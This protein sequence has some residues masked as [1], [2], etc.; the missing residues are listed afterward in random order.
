V[1][2]DALRGLAA[3]WVLLF[4]MRAGGHLPHLA[5]RWP[6]ALDTVIAHGDWGVVIFFALSGFVISHATGTSPL[7]S[8]RAWLL[9]GRR[10]LRLLPPY[11]VSLFVTVTL[12]VVS[13]HFVAGKSYPLPSLGRVAVHLALL[14]DLL[15]VPPLASVYWSLAVELQL[16]IAFYVSMLIVARLQ[17]WWSANAAYALVFGAALLGE[18]TLTRGLAQVPALVQRSFLPHWHW[19]ALGAVVWRWRIA[20][21]PEPATL[22]LPGWLSAVAGA[23]PLA[24]LGAV[25]YSLYLLHNPL[26]G[27]VFRVGRRLGLDTSELG[28][29]VS[30]ALATGVSLLAA[31]A[32]YWAVERPSMAWSRRLGASAKRATVA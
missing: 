12:G 1:E 10:C 6:S 19:F 21:K 23:A 18:W 8:S 32:M 26:T 27:A 7:S 13:T 17:R 11:W 22:G 31:A 4:H 2:L 24:W 29:C 5:Q 20:G 3:F 28:E 30:L 14:Q 9:F 15:N 25:S 16:Y